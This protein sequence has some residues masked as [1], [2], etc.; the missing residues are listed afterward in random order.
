MVCHF[1]ADFKPRHEYLKA[2]I[3]II[4]YDISLGSLHRLRSFDFH[5]DTLAARIKDGYNYGKRICSEL[6]AKGKTPL[7]R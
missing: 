1:S 6:F 5:G 4:D 3:P 2:N 7:S